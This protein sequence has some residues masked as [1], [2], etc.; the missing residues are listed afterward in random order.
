MNW[1]QEERRRGR[2]TN[3]YRHRKQRD[4]PD[5]S[6]VFLQVM[7][8]LLMSLFILGLV[9]KLDHKIQRASA[10]RSK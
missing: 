8:V 9:E 5:L 10:R 6:K 7:A 2:D 4:W 3:R 1:M